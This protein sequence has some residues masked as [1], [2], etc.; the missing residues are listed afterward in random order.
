[1]EV[2]V[3]QGVNEQFLQGVSETSE[4]GDKKVKGK[5]YGDEKKENKNTV[6]IY[7]LFNFADST[8]ILLMIRNSG[9]WVFFIP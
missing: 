6:P 7:K 2:E 3:T 9:K 4:K 8:D 1:M 5:K